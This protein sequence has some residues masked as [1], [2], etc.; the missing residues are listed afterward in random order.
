MGGG[1]VILQNSRQLTLVDLLIDDDALI[2]DM[3]SRL[4]TADEHI[5]VYQVAQDGDA[6]IA[7]CTFPWEVDGCYFFYNA[8]RM[9]TPY[10]ESPRS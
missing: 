1:G 5:A 8:R 9:V 4:P 2:I 6:N 10:F 7:Q 3:S